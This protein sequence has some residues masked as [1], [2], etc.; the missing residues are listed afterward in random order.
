[1]PYFHSL[2]AGSNDYVSVDGNTVICEVPTNRNIVAAMSSY[3]VMDNSNDET[4]MSTCE[5]T[6]ELPVSQQEKL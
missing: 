3:A 6:S 5:L 2:C 1:V 4:K